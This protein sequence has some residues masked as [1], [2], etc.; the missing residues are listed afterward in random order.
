MTRQRPVRVVHLDPDGF[1]DLTTER[2]LFEAA[3]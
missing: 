1:D 3:F 2:E